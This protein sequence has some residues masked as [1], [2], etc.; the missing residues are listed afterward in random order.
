MKKFILTLLRAL[1]STIGAMAQTKF[2]ESCRNN[3]EFETVYIGKAMLRMVNSSK[4]HVQGMNLNTVVDKLESIQ[5][6]TTEKKKPAKQLKEAAYTEFSPAT[7]YEIMMEANDNDDTTTIFYKK[8]KNNSNEYV[9]INSS[10]DFHETTVIIL[11]GSITPE[12]LKNL[13]RL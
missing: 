6:I 4:L 8:L 7:Q 11:T 13:K 3:P 10:T 12:D 9:L 1:F 5:V 2:Y